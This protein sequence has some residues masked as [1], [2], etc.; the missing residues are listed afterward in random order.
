MPTAMD[1][2]ALREIIAVKSKRFRILTPILKKMLLETI[3]KKWN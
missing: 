2:I 1:I 3:S